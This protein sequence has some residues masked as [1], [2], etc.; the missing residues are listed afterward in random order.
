[1]VDPLVAEIKA[2]DYILNPL[3]QGIDKRVHR[4]QHAHDGLFAGIVDGLS[5]LACHQ[6][7][8]L[9]AVFLAMMMS[10]SRVKVMDFSGTRVA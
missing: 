4:Q 10:S 1:M 3:L 5:L 6:L 7:P 9:P 2:R 8:A